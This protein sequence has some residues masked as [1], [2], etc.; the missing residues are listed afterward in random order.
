MATTNRDTEVRLQTFR[1]LDEQVA[2][3]GDVLPRALLAQGFNYEGHRGAAWSAK[4]LGAHEA[5][6]RL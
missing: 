1:W 6:V 4:T 3:H 2:L 5:A